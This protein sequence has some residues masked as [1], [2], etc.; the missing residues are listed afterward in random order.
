[1]S[2][3]SPKLFPFNSNYNHGSVEILKEEYHILID[4]KNDRRKE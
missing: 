3:L 4:F 1:M 2:Q